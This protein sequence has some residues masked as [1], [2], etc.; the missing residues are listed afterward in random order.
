MY[1]FPP[2]FVHIFFVSLCVC[3]VFW[4]FIPGALPFYLSTRIKWHTERKLYKR[5]TYRATYHAYY[6]HFI[7]IAV[8]TNMMKMDLTARKAKIYCCLFNANAKYTHMT[9][10]ISYAL[11]VP[12]YQV[13]GL[14]SVHNTE[15]R[16]S[17]EEK[18]EMPKREKERKYR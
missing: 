1:I 8:D 7:W 12:L 6:T 18:R 2:D 15:K 17:E 11:E 16:I 3:F 9:Q 5:Y 13:Y 14:L 4:F 10:T